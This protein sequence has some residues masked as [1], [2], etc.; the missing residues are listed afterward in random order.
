MDKTAIAELLARAG[1]PIQ[2][3]RPIR[4]LIDSIAHLFRGCR[5]LRLQVFDLTSQR[6]VE[7]GRLCPVCGT[8][9][10]PV[11]GRTQRGDRS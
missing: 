7:V 6:L 3:R 10:G 9:S 5:P 2:E 4:N 1:I 11:D 8:E